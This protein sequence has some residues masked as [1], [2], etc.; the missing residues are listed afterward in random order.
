MRI[1]LVRVQNEQESNRISRMNSATVV[2]E[3]PINTE[4]ETAKPVRAEETKKIIT[5]NLKSNNR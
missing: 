2:A 4:V 3:K 5:K 1:T